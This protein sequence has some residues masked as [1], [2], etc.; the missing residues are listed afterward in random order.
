MKSH[1]A[2]KI[3]ENIQI[4]SNFGHFDLTR[5]EVMVKGK[6]I[7]SNLLTIDA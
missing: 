1:F 3:V 6:K 7:N 2:F 5:Q 4:L